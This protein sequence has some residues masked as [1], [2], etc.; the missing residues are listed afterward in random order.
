MAF[1]YTI[2]TTIIKKT[3]FKQKLDRYTQK[4]HMWP[5]TVMLYS[6]AAAAATAPTAKKQK[7]TVLFPATNQLFEESKMREINI[8][9]ILHSNTHRY[10]YIS[11]E[12]SSSVIVLLSFCSLLVFFFIFFFSIK[13]FF[14]FF[15][16]CFRFLLFSRIY[17]CFVL[18]SIL[19]LTAIKCDYSALC[20]MCIM[21]LSCTRTC[22]H[23]SNPNNVGCTII[24]IIPHSTYTTLLSLSLSFFL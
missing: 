19:H 24:I 2:S 3:A 18:D 11:S 20:R 23:F 10:K 17:L 9:F 22:A 13:Q 5:Y 4:I 16:N 15:L 14:S 6:Y 8:N 7:H 12:R 21:C 1:R